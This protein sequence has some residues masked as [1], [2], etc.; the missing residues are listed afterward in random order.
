MLD[1]LALK[2]ALKIDY[3]VPVR[4]TQTC[5]HYTT[6]NGGTLTIWRDWHHCYFKHGRPPKMKKAK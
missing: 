3:S 6:V 2:T 1:L 5:N 4:R